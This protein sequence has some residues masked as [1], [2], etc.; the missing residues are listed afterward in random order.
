MKILE[1]KKKQNDHHHTQEKQTSEI[2]V[3]DFMHPALLLLKVLLEQLKNCKLKVSMAM[4]QKAEHTWVVEDFLE[5]I[6][7]FL[8]R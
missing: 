6:K 3:W 7:S 8:K 4:I 5:V 1:L 2:K